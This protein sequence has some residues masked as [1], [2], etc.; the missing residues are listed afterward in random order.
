MREFNPGSIF[1]ISA[2]P[3]WGEHSQNSV[4]WVPGCQEK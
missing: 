4:G 1:A 2:I 3:L